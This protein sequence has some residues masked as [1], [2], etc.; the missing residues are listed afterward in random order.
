[1]TPQSSLLLS[2][3]RA[4]YEADKSVPPFG[5]LRWARWE[6]LDPETV[7][8][9]VGQMRAAL[10][11]VREPSLEMKDAGQPVVNLDSEMNQYEFLSVD[12][13]GEIFTA[14]ID[15]LLEAP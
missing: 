4:H 2:M 15:K 12:E 13:I 5:G 6:E 11:V 14:M 8:R 7:E 3:A 1:M 10:G 9:K